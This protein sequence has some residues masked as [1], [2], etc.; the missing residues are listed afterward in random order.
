MISWWCRVGIYYESG[1]SGRDGNLGRA[2]ARSGVQKVRWDRSEVRPWRQQ[3]RCRGSGAS[4]GWVP[5]PNG[6]QARTAGEGDKRPEL[7]N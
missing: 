5:P 1:L 3:S 7:I 6:A 2:E 4:G